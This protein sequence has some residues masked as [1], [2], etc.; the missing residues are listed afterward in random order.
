MPETDDPLRTLRRIA[1][2]VGQVLDGADKS[3]SISFDN[4]C[5]L[6]PNG[7]TISEIEE[8]ILRLE[9]RGIA[10]D[11]EDDEGPSEADDEAML[12]ALRDFLMMGHAMLLL[13]PDE[14]RKLARSMDGTNGRE[15]L[16]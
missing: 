10:V 11:D 13:T 12:E 9:A 3:G 4:L 5:R 6:V 7:A 8:L 15:P 2:D 1:D 16:A 14:W